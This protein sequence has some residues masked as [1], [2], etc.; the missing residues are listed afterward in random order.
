M[1]S[2]NDQATDECWIFDPMTK[3]VSKIACLPAKQNHLR[4]TQCDDYV[5]GIAG[6]EIFYG[7]EGEMIASHC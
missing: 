4:L 3:S 6:I 1:E 2:M 7:E 5:Y